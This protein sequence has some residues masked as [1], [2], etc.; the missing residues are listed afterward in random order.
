MNYFTTNYSIEFKLSYKL[1]QLILIKTHFTYVEKKEKHICIKIPVLLILFY[2]NICHFFVTK[3]FTLS[4]LS[5][6]KQLR[7]I[8]QYTSVEITKLP[9]RKKTIFT[10]KNDHLLIINLTTVWCINNDVSNNIFNF[11]FNKE[12]NNKN[13]HLTYTCENYII[14]LCKYYYKLSEDLLVIL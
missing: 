8:L 6:F 2:L 13:L 5:Y 4:R 10:T 3:V 14:I 11:H 7:A 12:Y 9:Q 1:Q